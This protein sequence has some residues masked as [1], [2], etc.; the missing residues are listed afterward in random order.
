M[1]RPERFWYEGARPPLW[2]W[3]L[4]RLFCALAGLRRWAYTK[5]LASVHRMPVPVIVVGNIAVGGTGK[6]PLVI[7]LA[8]WL[9]AR[10]WRPGIVSRGYK[11][12]AERWPLPVSADSSPHL[13]G[14]EPVLI[15]RRTGCPLWV[16]PDRVDAARALLAAAECD[17]ILSDDGLQHYRLGRDLEIAVID[18]E[19][20]LGNRRCLPAGPL[21]EAPGRLDAVDLLVCNGGQPQTRE[22]GMALRPGALVNLRRPDRERELASLVGQ[23][24]LALAGIGN[25]GRFFALL[26]GAGLEVEER[27]FPDH[28]EYRA[29]DLPSEADPRALLMTEKDAVKLAGMARNNDWCLPVKAELDPV[30]EHRLDLL[31][32]G[33]T[34]G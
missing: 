34:D 15:A 19:R 25:P 17:I 30:F 11:G 31:L 10:G 32:K 24:V 7:W 18:G 16:G 12:Q 4:G 13:V 23:R 22:F 5:G 14:D 26:R 3:P 21:R 1:L 6:T 27:A 28:H 33:F 29:R 2:T 20:R 9:R 8:G